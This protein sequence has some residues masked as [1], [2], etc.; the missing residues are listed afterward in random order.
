MPRELK[1]VVVVTINQIH[2]NSVSIKDF[3]D[4]T[5]L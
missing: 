3:P 1:V 2:G 4:T 5:N